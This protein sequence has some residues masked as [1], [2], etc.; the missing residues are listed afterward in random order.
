LRPRNRSKR[1]IIGE[2]LQ[3]FLAC[4]VLV[5]DGMLAAAD[6]FFVACCAF[7]H[8]CAFFVSRE[9]PTV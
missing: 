4:A 2:K 9:W 3:Q 1:W 8:V 5:G 6:S 7:G